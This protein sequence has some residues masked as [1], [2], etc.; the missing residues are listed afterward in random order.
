MTIYNSIT[1]LVGKTPVINLTLLF[2]KDQQMF[3]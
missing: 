3:T 2:Q 1:E